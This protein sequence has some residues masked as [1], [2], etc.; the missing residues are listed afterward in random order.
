MKNMKWVTLFSLVWLSACG[1]KPGSPVINNPA[2]DIFNSKYVRLI[3]DTN[4]LMM[5]ENVV[6]RYGDLYAEADSALLDKSNQTVTVFAIKKALF[7]GDE[8]DRNEYKD[9][10]RYK[11]GDARF[12]TD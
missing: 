3:G 5:I 12:Y 9:M 6:I 1:Q 10:I 4:R 2:P 7:K 8:I 11:K